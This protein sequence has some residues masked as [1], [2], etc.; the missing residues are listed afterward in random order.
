M[1]NKAHRRGTHRAIVLRATVARIRSAIQVL[2]ITL[3]DD[4]TRW[5]RIGIPV[6]MVV[7]AE[8]RCLGVA[9]GKGLNL[10]AAVASGIMESVESWHAERVALSVQ[11]A[12]AE[13]L[14]ERGNAIAVWQL[15]LRR[16]GS[17]NN[18]RR[19]PWLE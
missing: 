15:P 2:G 14:A 7:R 10:D 16:D 12:S 11:I 17:L 1:I 18:G 13:E 6:V 4:V 9:Q 8:G 19:I 5:D 3:I